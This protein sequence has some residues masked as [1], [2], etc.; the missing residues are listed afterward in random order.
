MEKERGFGKNIHIVSDPFHEQ[1][2]ARFSTNEVKQPEANRLARMLS[3]CLG[4]AAINELFP[5]KSQ[6]YTTRMNEP[7]DAETCDRATKAVVV[8]LMRAGILPSSVVY[9]LL[10][11][12]LPA[13]NIRQDHILLNRATD[14]NEQVI[15][16]QMSGHKIGGPIEGAYVFL[17]DPMGATG[18]SIENVIKLYDTLS[19]GKPKKFIAL[20]FIVTPE[21]LKRLQPLQDRLEIFSLRVDRGLNEKQYILPGAGGIGEILNNS[22][23]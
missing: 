7:L 12:V 18:S 1:I 23:V 20:H 13:E 16:V 10:H 9:E 14:K 5:K 22:F 11:E 15:G 17:P 4:V 8:D 3:Q 19:L 21:Y 6:R 2:L